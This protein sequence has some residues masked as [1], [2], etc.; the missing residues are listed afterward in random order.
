MVFSSTIHHCCRS[1]TFVLLLAILCLLPF[2]YAEAEEPD[3]IITEQLASMMES[4]DCGELVS[5][6]VLLDRFGEPS[7]VIGY[8]EDGYL[9][10]ESSTYA[11][12]EQGTGAG[13]YSPESQEKIYGGFG[14]YT[15]KINDELVDALTGEEL[16]AIPYLPAAESL[17]DEKEQE[18]QS[19]SG[20]ADI[21]SEA[22]D[23]LLEWHIY[24]Y[25]EKIL[26]V[27]FGENGGDLN[28]T[29]TAVAMSI[30]LNYL[31]SEFDSKLVPSEFELENWTER[32]QVNI[33]STRAHAFHRYLVEECGLE[34]RDVLPDVTLG[35]WG[36]QAKD[37]F[38]SYLDKNSERQSTGVAFSWNLDGAAQILDAIDHNCPVLITTLVDL[39]QGQHGGIDYGQHTMVV[40]GYRTAAGGSIEVNVHSGWFDSAKTSDVDSGSSVVNPDEQKYMSD[41]WLPADIALMTYTFN[42]SDG[43]HYGEDG[44]WRY[45]EGGAFCTGWKEI[46]AKKYYFGEGGSRTVG[47]LTQ[48]GIRYLF[49]ADGVLISQKDIGSASTGGSVTDLW[50]QFRDC[51]EGDLNAS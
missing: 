31:D 8:S 48:N 23:A 12:M 17:V 5:S 1:M 36:E 32:L 43:W 50:S 26:G 29:C 46:D 10:I 14:C 27:L 34:A 51:V 42:L 2:K 19:K 49:N 25:E 35:V 30:A 13:P 15:E 21:P 28:N 41:I 3:S 33:S 22:A 45:F 24:K 37:G 20:D 4:R 18:R 7:Y 39:W 44:A 6:E 38:Y 11:F 9:I 16:D 47:Y 40:Y